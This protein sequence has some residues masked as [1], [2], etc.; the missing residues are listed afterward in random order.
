MAG[1]HAHTCACEQHSW[2]I[3]KGCVTMPRLPVTK[4]LTRNSVR[5]KGLILFKVWEGMQSIGW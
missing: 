3:R 1:E 2:N 5:E 4:F